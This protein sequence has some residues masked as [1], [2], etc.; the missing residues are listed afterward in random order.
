MTTLKYVI[1]NFNI[2]ILKENNCGSCNLFR[3]VNAQG[4]HIP[5]IEL[6]GIG[7]VAQGFCSQEFGLLLSLRT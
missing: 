4:E 1:I 3:I 6:P 5:R 7:L 2:M